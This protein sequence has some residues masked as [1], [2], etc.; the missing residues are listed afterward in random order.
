MVDQSWD[1]TEWGRSDG[2]GEDGWGWEREW[3]KET[4]RIESILRG[5]METVQWKHPK[6]Y[7]GNAKNVSK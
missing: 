6:I 3:R 7:G 2:E 4:D 5:G 1:E